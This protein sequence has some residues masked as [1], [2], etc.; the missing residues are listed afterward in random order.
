MCIY[1]AF[2]L[3]LYGRVYL[4]SFSSFPLWT[5]VSIHLF[6]YGCVCLPIFSSFPLWTCV[7]IHIFLYG[8]VY[9]SIVSSVWTC[10]CLHLFLCINMCSYPAF[11]V[12]WHVRLTVSNNY[13]TDNRFV[14]TC[15]VFLC[16]HSDRGPSFFTCRSPVLCFAVFSFVAWLFVL[17]F[18]RHDH[19]HGC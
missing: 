8:H 19:M 11:S 13:S 6:L 12:V 7:S 9:L 2:P 16:L 1:P 3:F 14:P 4:S 10:V 5:C 15:S 18:H 17:W